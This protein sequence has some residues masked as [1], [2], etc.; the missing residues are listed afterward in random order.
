MQLNS[1]YDQY[2]VLKNAF[3]ESDDIKIKQAAQSVQ[4][5][6]TKTDTK[7]LTGDLMSKWMDES[8]M[9]NQE[10]KL[11]TSETNIEDQRTAFISFNDN[12]YNTIKSFGLMGKTVYYQ[13]CPM[14]NN[15]QGAYW[16]SETKEI[17]NPYY[18]EAMLTCGET[19]ETLNY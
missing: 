13:F 10:I 16:L 9:L 17:R 7:L 15:S 11:I 3:V 4:Q 5:A 18:G 12:F 6:L 14:A 1:V 19:K 8:A 2:L